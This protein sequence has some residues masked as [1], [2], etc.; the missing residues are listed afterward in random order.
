MVRA[1]WEG[2][3]IQEQKLVVRELTAAEVAALPEWVAETVGIMGIAV[4]NG[5]GYSSD[6]KTA[7]EKLEW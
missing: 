2:K 6:E 4:H 3:T 1:T 5:I 7:R